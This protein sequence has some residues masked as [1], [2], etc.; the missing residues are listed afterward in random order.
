MRQRGSR[1][2]YTILNEPGAAEVL[3]RLS[4]PLDLTTQAVAC[5][6]MTKQTRAK[7]RRSRQMALPCV[8]SRVSVANL[9]KR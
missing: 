7:P 3:N 2:F 6:E 4:L 5:I 1:P 9:R 8:L